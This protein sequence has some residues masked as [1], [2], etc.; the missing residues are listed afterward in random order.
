MYSQFPTVNFLGNWLI[1][2]GD[3]DWVGNSVVHSRW[4]RGSFNDFVF[5]AFPGISQLIIDIIAIIDYLVGN[6]RVAVVMFFS[7]QKHK[8][9]ILCMWVC[10]IC[11]SLKHCTV[12]PC[13]KIVFNSVI[14]IHNPIDK[15]NRFKGA[16]K[17]SFIYFRP[18]V[19]WNF[20][21]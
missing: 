6:P 15:S 8:I 17:F 1:I 13:G 3:K 21:N 11:L 14:I 7:P 19:K 20:N 4:F 2:Q 12:Y 10:I 18:D 16:V 9:V 5:L